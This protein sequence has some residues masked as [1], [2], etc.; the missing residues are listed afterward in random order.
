MIEIHALYI[1]LAEQR[2]LDPSIANLILK[3]ILAEL[4]VSRCAGSGSP[5]EENR[6]E[7]KKK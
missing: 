7:E 4:K 1:Y 6:K 3:R 2:D 5:S